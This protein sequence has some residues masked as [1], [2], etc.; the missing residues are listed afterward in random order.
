MTDFATLTTDAQGFLRQLAR[1][2]TKGWWD[3]NRAIYDDRLK[4]A[5]QALI[6][7]MTDQLATL[8]ELPVTGKLFR[9][10]RD[11]RFSKDK[12]PYKTHM[13][14]LWTAQTGGRQDVAFF[15]GIDTDGVRA[16]GGIMGFDKPVLDDWRLFVDQDHKRILAITDG[17]ASRGFSFW[18]PALKRVPQGY[19]PDHPA[20]TLLRMKGCVALQ[21][22]GATPRLPQDLSTAFKDLWPLNQ[23]LI[24]IVEA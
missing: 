10:H 13:H 14:M 7:A 18:E 6:A 8:S 2:N 21:D 20:A 4:P 15:F 9:P 24:Q 12:T 16:G 3:D 22:I 17:L 5:A 11:V 23:L 1:N 19:A